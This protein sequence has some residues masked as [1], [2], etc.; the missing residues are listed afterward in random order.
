MHLIFACLQYPRPV[1]PKVSVSA[2]ELWVV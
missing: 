1:N 2:T